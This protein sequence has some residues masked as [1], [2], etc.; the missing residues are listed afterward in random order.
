MISEYIGFGNLTLKINLPQ[1]PVGENLYREF[2][3][4]A[5]TP[6]Y[7]VTFCF[8]NCLPQ[9]DK[10]F[11][12][13]DTFDYIIERK[14][15]RLRCFYKN[16]SGGG[17]YAVRQQLGESSRI[18][19]FLDRSVRDKLWTRLILNTIGVEELAVKKGGIVFH[20]SFIQKD[21]RAV[22]FTGPCSIGKSTQAKLWKDERGTPIIN[23][24]KTYLY[25]D[26]GTVFAS[27]LPF[28]GSSGIC[29]NERMPLAFIVKLEKAT[30]NRVIKL[31]KM[32]AFFAVA[33]SCYV[34]FGFTAQASEIAAAIA[35]S[36]HICRLSCL[37][38]VT[39]VETLEEFM[40]KEKRQ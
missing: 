38:D 25:F 24:D 7:E 32:D 28:S 21:G 10:G 17:F 19:I 35:Q 1:K 12:C 18:F 39:A 31:T 6:D 15:N 11:I 30:E 14:R 27:G 40:E 20:S 23:G 4:E 13:S 29:H 22:L 34:P 3:C 37:P 36:S 8:C 5:K 9:P 26:N 2:I 16:R 33:D